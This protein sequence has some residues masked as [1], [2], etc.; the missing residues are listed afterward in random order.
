MVGMI[1]AVKSLAE[2]NAEGAASGLIYRYTGWRTWDNKWSA[3]GLK[4]GLMP[5]VIGGI[6]HKYVGGKLGVNRALSQAGIPIIRI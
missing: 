2:G 3:T 1:P 4:S 6:V 5:L